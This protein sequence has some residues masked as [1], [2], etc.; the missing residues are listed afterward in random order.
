MA[1]PAS[2]ALKT[3]S[4]PMS[5]ASC[6]KSS[7]LAGEGSVSAPDT[8]LM[9]LSKSMAVFAEAAPIAASGTVTPAVMVSPASA[10]FCPALYIF[11]PA[12]AALEP[13]STQL[14]DM[15]PSA[16][17]VLTARRSSDFSALSTADEL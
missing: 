2:D 4:A 3:V 9:L 8:R 7:M 12:S 11:P 6:R 10:T 17:A 15:E 16:A 14:F 13:A 5:K 1:A